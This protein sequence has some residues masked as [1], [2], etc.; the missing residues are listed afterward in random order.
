MENVDRKVWR[1]P[2][3]CRYGSFAEATTQGCDKTLGSTDGFTFLGLDIV[4]AS[5]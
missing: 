3:A 1:T 4:C 2:R 5:P